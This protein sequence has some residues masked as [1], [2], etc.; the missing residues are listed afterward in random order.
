MDETQLLLLLEKDINSGFRQLIK[1]YSQT[2]YWHV[3]KI[4]YSHADAD[5][6]TQ[7]VFIKVFQN[8]Q[9][10]KRNSSLKTWIYKIAT[11]ESLNFINSAA[12]KKNI[13][14][15]E[16]V[17]LLSS[18]LKDDNFFDGDEI[19]YKLQQAIAKLPEKQRIVFNMKYFDNIKYED[20]SEILETSVGALKSSYYHATKKVEQFLLANIEK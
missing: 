2:I 16:L 20:M 3:R 19:Q 6:I 7:N 11:H 5:D 10:F 1:M 18:Q 14:N 9:G 15:E 4:V 17:I 8:L 13:R 12:Q